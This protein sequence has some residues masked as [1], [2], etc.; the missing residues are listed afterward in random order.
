MRCGVAKA[1]NIENWKVT[2]DGDAR[3]AWYFLWG[4]IATRQISQG[5]S[6]SSE[7]RSRAAISISTIPILSRSSS[8][9]NFDSRP[10]AS[11]FLCENDRTHDATRRGESAEARGVRKMLGTLIRIVLGRRAPFKSDRV[12][13]PRL[14]FSQ[15]IEILAHEGILYLAEVESRVFCRITGFRCVY[16]VCNSGCRT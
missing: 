7:L 14:R 9:K 12:R 11:S 15:P 6:L 1:R 5:G 4:E 13:F 2:I 3:L 16:R 10:D 8:Y